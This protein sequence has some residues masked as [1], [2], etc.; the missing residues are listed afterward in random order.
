MGFV[1]ISDR[2]NGFATE[3]LRG[4]ASRVAYL[5]DQH[6]PSIEVVIASLRAVQLGESVLDPTI[7]ESLISRT[8][9]RPVDQLTPRESDVLEQMAHGMSNAAIA[10]ELHLSIKSIEKGV[11][12]IFLKL[13]PFDPKMVDRRV[14]ACLEYL[15]S[16]TDPFGQAPTPAPLGTVRGEPG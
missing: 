5:L 7:V 10:S 8:G 14:S 12:A 6:L 1:V 16:Q 13:G 4:G 9:D 2:A 15:R 11:T 3:L